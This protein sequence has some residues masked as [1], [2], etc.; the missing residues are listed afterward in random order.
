MVMKKYLF[1]TIAVLLPLIA[2]NS[3]SQNTSLQV[4]L[5]GLRNAKGHVLVSVFRTEAGFPDDPSKAVQKQRVAVN[6]DKAVAK[7]NALPIGT[8]AVAVLHD[9]NDDLKMDKNFVGI[10][11]E[12]Y[13]FSNN[14]IRLTGPPSFKEASFEHDKNQVLEIKVKY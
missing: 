4:D 7:F 12:G 14:A 11:K 3:F 6:G 9:E 10:P 1:R 13:G 8:Y 5:S 2:L